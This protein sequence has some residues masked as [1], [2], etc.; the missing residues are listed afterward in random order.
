MDPQSPVYQDVM[1]ATQ[2][3]GPYPQF[4]EIP[5]IPTDVR[6]V[7]A[8]FAS[9]AEVEHDKSSL[10]TAVAALPPVPADTE[11]FAANALSEAKAPAADAPPPDAADQ[12]Q[13]YAQS[14]RQ[15]AIPP[16]KRR[17]HKR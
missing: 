17:A 3:P 7:S 5:K 10:N 13:A 16:P 14:L 11:S 2:H 9:V 6:P 1:A 8:W 15:R 4:A 12:S